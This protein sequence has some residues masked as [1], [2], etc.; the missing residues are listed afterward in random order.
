MKKKAIVAGAGIA[1]LAMARA[2]ALKGYAVTVFEKNEKAVGASVRNFGM[3]WPVGQPSGLLYE[4]ALATK[5]IWKTIAGATGLWHNESGSVHTA[6]HRDEWDVL[7]ELATIF[8]AEGRPVQLLRKDEAIARF[9]AINPAN[10]R[11]GL[12]SATEMV[13]DPRV[14][15]ASVADYLAGQ[16]NVKFVWDKAVTAVENGKIHTGHETHEADIIVLCS[17][18]DI[19]T[20]YPRVLR[21]NGMTTCKPQM[22][23]FKSDDEHFSIGASLCGGLSL[24]HYNSF[25]AAGTLEALRQRYA[26]EMPEYLAHGIHVMVSQNDKGELTVGDSHAYGGVHDPFDEMPINHLIRD[27]LNQFVTTHRWK[28]IQTWNG[29]YPKLTDGRSHLFAE[30]DKGV[31]IFNGL[32]GAGMTLGLGLAEA[33]VNAVL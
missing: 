30:A 27:Y 16:Q 13:V 24:I 10:F 25:K 3:I 5:A 32:G 8:A 31:Y 14:A 21:D 22:M 15:I 33:A 28:L 18:A 26:R 17:G 23:R 9:P 19:Q 2:L 12:Y 1:G 20:L 7:Q 11:G 4:T 29:I 6:Y